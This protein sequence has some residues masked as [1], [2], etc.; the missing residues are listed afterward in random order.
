MYFPVK[1]KSAYTAFTPIHS[2]PLPLSSIYTPLIPCPSCLTSPSVSPH[3]CARSFTFST[4]LSPP[5][6]PISST[7]LS[8]T[9]F[10]PLFLPPPLSSFHH[11]IPLS[12]QTPHL[13]QVLTW[14]FKTQTSIS[15]PSRKRNRGRDGLQQ[16]CVKSG[17]FFLIILAHPDQV[18]DKW[19]ADLWR[20]VGS[21]HDYVAEVCRVNLSPWKR[22]AYVRWQSWRHVLLPSLQDTPGLFYWWELQGFPALLKQLNRLRL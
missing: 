6:V 1:R 16:T 11:F 10:L 17:S 22:A 20:N 2:S 15:H 7:H 3:T 18:T 13:T 14:Y 5:S 12:V 21:T 8:I 19:A 9:S 4:S